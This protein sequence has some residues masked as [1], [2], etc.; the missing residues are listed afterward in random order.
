MGPAARSLAS[1]ALLA[2]L[3][4]AAEAHAGPPS[5]SAPRAREVAWR[6]EWPRFSPWEGA[7]TLGATVGVYVAERR[8]PDPDQARVSFE[9]PLLD[10]GVRWLLRG[11]SRNVQQ[12]FARYSDIGFRMMA[13]LPYVVDDGIAALGFHQNPDVAAQL[14][15]I[16]IQA[17][18]LSGATQLLVSRAVGRER[19]YVQDLSLIHI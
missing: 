13:F 5:L 12:G 19:P 2:A 9:V 16:D 10:P 11:R 18:T 15:L 8:L 3:A 7:V 17:L 14:F 1:V 6:D 4:S